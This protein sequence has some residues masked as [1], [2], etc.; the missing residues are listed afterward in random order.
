MFGMDPEYWENYHTR[1]VNSN[2][3]K[4][5]VGEHPDQWGACPAELLPGYSKQHGDVPE[6]TG[7]VLTDGRIIPGWVKVVDRHFYRSNHAGVIVNPA[8]G[9]FTFVVHTAGMN[10]YF[11]IRFVSFKFLSQNAGGDFL[12]PLADEIKE[13]LDGYFWDGEPSLESFM[14][15]C[16]MIADKILWHGLK[17][18][19]FIK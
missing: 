12:D 10:A 8:V 11:Y 5:N 7:L 9:N 17:E 15:D 3:R 1:M 4:G 14:D 13:K 19:G 16:K 2:L 18:Q 6:L